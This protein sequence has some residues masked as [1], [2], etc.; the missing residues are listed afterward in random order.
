MR[1]KFILTLSLALASVTAMASTSVDKLSQ[2]QLEKHYHTLVQSNEASINKI[3]SFLLA[4]NEFSAGKQITPGEFVQ[5]V[6]G[7]FLAE[8]NKN[9][10]ITANSYTQDPQVSNF[11]DLAQTCNE[12]FRRNSALL[13]NDDTCSFVA[14]IY[15]TAG[16][17]ANA[18]QSMALLGTLQTLE[19]NAKQG[20]PLDRRQQALVQAKDKLRDYNLGFTLRLPQESY[21]LNPETREQIY[22]LYHVRLV[23]QGE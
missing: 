20:T 9:F 1:H 14:A 21:F 16:Y 15:L 12:L 5:F 13:K 10:G 6:S 18:L 3:K 11:V 19:I 22:N 23:G 17:D 2:T 8:L 4:F 7:S